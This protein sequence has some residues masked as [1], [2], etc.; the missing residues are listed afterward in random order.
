MRKV[1]RIRDPRKKEIVAAWCAMAIR[2]GRSI[3]EGFTVCK[4]KDALKI[5]FAFREG[6]SES[7]TNAW[8]RAV[9]DNLGI[10]LELAGYGQVKEIFGSLSQFGPRRR[11]R[12]ATRRGSMLEAA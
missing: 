8:T 4:E 6:V 7:W 5:I 3:L 2:R 1:I 9:M 11:R 12:I 10:E